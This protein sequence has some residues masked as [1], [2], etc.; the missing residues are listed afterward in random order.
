MARDAGFSA[1]F[2]C[3]GV[4]AVFGTVRAFRREI[5][6]GTMAMA[7]AHPIS[8][9][10][11][12]L[13]KVLGSLMAY[14]V[15]STVV[16]GTVIVI[17]EGAALGGAIAKQSGDIAR[18]YGPFLVGGVAILLLPMVLAAVLN[19]FARFRFVLTSF[20]LAFVLSVCAA[21]AAVVL[22]RGP[23]QRLLPAAALVAQMAVVLLSAAAAFAMR[24]KASAAVSIVGAVFVAMVPAIGNYYLVDAL[25]GAGRITWA[26]VGC[27]AVAALPAVVA[28]L[29]MGIHFANGRDIS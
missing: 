4:V 26:Y 3:G 12:F 6:S 17:Y 22:T 9:S 27:A 19:R 16:F 23:I 7:L 5:E 8:R 10:G 11:F 15:F 21:V 14:V 29:L 2:T 18:I 1:L 20:V 13:A 28:F 24:F 25:S